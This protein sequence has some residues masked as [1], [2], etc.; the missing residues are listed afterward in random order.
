MKIKKAS[1][2]IMYTGHLPYNLENQICV[3]AIASILDLRYTESIREKEGG[4]YG[5]GVRGRLS[6]EPVNQASINI[7]FD[8]DPEKQ[9][10][11]MKLIHLEIDTLAEKGPKAEDLT[12]VKENLLKTYAE[13]I[14]ENAWWQSAVVLFD[15]DKINYLSDFKNIVEKLTADDIKNTVGKI[16]EQGNI[17]EVVMKPE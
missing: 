2:Y 9:A 14:R 17:L 13:D 11:L 8:T 7:S 15:R 16:T 5:V 3:E 1:N 4:T 12:K 10:H 6:K